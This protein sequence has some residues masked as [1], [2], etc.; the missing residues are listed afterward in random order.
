[1]P[2]RRDGFCLI[3]TRLRYL[4]F[5]TIGRGCFYMLTITVCAFLH[6]PT[7]LES[8]PRGAFFHLYDTRLSV[9]RALGKDS[10][11]TVG[12]HSDKAA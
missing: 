3:L 9:T 2:T 4:R 6:P 5:V 11:N 12:K 7:V 1:M 8:Y 10:N